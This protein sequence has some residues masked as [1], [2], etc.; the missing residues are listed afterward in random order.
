[1]TGAGRIEAVI[2]DLD[3][4]LVD[5][6]PHA[7][8]AIAAEMRAEGIVEARADEIGRDYLGVSM[9]DL[10]R[11]IARRLGREV[12]GDFVE[13]VETRLFEVYERRL[14]RIEGALGLLDRL[15]AA[16]VARAIAT[17]GSI[18]RMIGTLRIGGLSERFEGRA[19]SA[20]RVARGKPAPDVFLLAAEGLGVSPERCAVLEDSPHGIAGAFAA[21]MRPVGFVGGSHL[22]PIRDVHRSRLI[23]AGAVEVVESLGAA[24]AALTAGR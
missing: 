11:D 7:L 17:G 2:F 1:M 5:S 9:T 24:Y 15:E 6:E 23:D 4:C 10:C 21:G 19:F 3:G 8:E 22:D 18:R 12:P 14:R 13:R 20:E 16:G